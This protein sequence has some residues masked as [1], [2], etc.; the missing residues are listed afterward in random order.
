MKNAVTDKQLKDA[1]SAM[2]LSASGWRKVFAPDGEHG[3]SPLPSDADL[4]LALGMGV[5][6]GRWLKECGSGGGSG[7][8][9]DSTGAAAGGGN[10]GP[11][12][13]VVGAAGHGSSGR[14]DNVVGAAGH[15]RSGPAAGPVN[16]P[17]VLVATDT[18][19]TGPALAEM[20]MRGLESE[21]FGTIY[22]GIAAAPEAMARCAADDGITAF[23]YVSASHNP[24]GHNGV[25][26]GLGGGVIGG[27][28]ARGLIALYRILIEKEGSAAS[29]AS[30][31]ESDSG[32]AAAGRIPDR[33]EKAQTLI[34]YRN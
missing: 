4:L 19:P 3:P 20:V 2:I 18:R 9:A 13:N 24:L 34:A 12:D 6:W 22:T 10:F 5:A 17:M 16:R 23:A 25:K 31:L 32:A 11:S 27:D 21:G 14:T 1:L 8:A 29:L 28:D 30:L 7:S 15:G 26:F 33:A